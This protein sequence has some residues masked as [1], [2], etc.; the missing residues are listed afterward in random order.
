[1]SQVEFYIEPAQISEFEVLSNIEKSARSR[2]S[3]L[4]G[5]DHVV[6]SPPIEVE[7]FSVGTSFVAHSCDSIVGFVLTVP[8]DGMLYIA[9]ISVMP[10]VSGHGVGG[11]LLVEAQALASRLDLPALVLTTFKVPPWNGPW[12]RSQGYKPIPEQEI[13]REL[14]SIM[15]RQ[16]SQAPGSNPQERQTLWKPL[17][18]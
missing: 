14:R 7:R 8:L 12:F 17:N 3:S 4:Q 11:M 15:V 13:G 1:M 5:F 6:N 9:N 16:A 10:K 2:Y 18:R